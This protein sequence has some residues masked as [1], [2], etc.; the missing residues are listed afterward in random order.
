MLQAAQ[1]YEVRDLNLHEAHVLVRDP[2]CIGPTHVLG[3]HGKRVLTGPITQTQI[4]TS[5]IPVHSLVL[6]ANCAKLPPFPPSNERV[7]RNSDGREFILPVVPFLL[8]SRLCFPMLLEYLYRKSRL[9]LLARLFKTSEYPSEFNAASVCSALADRPPPFLHQILMDV[10][11][12]RDNACELGVYD[13]KFWD[14]LD[15]ARQEVIKVV[16]RRSGRMDTYELIV[17]TARALDQK[18]EPSGDGKEEEE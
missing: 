6:A 13:D 12:L 2:S 16:A 7:T 5:F 3:L 8:S 17:S 1:K 4:L 15:W 11:M 9:H 18:D 10:S 14:T